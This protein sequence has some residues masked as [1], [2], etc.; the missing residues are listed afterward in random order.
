MGLKY[1]LCVVLII[2]TLL[3]LGISYIAWKKRSNNVALSCSAVMFSASF[4]SLGYAFE[5]ISNN[6]EQVKMSLRIEYIGIPFLTAFWF[7]LVV[8]YVGYEIYINKWTYCALLFIPVV[9]FILHYTNDFH[10]LF[11]K[12]ISIEDDT[13]F[14]MVILD[15]GIWYWV[16]IGYSYLLL[17]IGIFLYIARYIRA[18]PIIR[19][20]IIIMLLGAVVPWM[21]NIIYLIAPVKNNIDLSPFGFVITGILYIIAIFKF[22][23]LRIRAIAL[24]SVF[25]SMEDAVIIL[26]SEND[27]INF[28]DSAKRIIKELNDFEII[29]NSGK[30]IFKEYPYILS[31][32]TNVRSD[33]TQ[34]IKNEV[35]RK[36][37]KLCVSPI[38][39]NKNILGKT[40]VLTD[41]T[42]QRELMKKLNKLATVDELTKVY[43]R[44]Y[45][46][47]QCKKEISRSQR[48]NIPISFII[49]DIDYFKKVN[50]NYG[51]HIG[52]L[53]LKHIVF[54]VK[55]HVRESDIIARYGGEEFAI[56]LPHTTG[57]S[58]V[59][60]AEKIRKVIWRTPYLLDNNEI[61][62][63]SSFGVYGCDFLKDESLDDIMVKSDRAL[64][65]AK[66]SGRN[67]VIM[68]SDISDI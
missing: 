33:D 29:N 30:E 2:T 22:N 39:Y 53:V 3:T 1:V 64:Y 56:L 4:Y 62:L 43:N 66:E 6:M 28:N 49:M 36:Y 21:L 68:Y 11:Y 16:H 25:K 42:E 19:K 15:R 45:F 50:D 47:K 32:I 35:G 37:F 41:I 55:N 65:R 9:T 10:H 51:H 38:R 34:C 13:F 44:R 20:Q 26:N 67:K 46:Y 63:T 8:R 27:I 14:T 54:I 23:L 57:K 31:S 12:G 5:V 61:K 58:A 24:E 59:E 17:T 52:D 48:Y 7:L 18:L 60:V 40:L